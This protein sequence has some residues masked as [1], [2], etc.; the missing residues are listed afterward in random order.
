MLKI[1]S[2]TTINSLKEGEL[3]QIIGYYYYSLNKND[4][5]IVEDNPIGY[6][7]A[8]MFLEK[9]LIDSRDVYKFL[10]YNKVIYIA[11]TKK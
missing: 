9:F 8:V 11:L 6:G 10:Y 2:L 1:K 4:L 7:E 5:N 3:Y